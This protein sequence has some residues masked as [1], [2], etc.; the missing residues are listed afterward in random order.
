MHPYKI[1]ST[2][3]YTFVCRHNTYFTPP[4]PSYRTL[5]S[6]TYRLIYLHYST[7]HHCEGNECVSVG[8]C[9]HEK[10]S[11]QHLTARP[12]SQW[13][14]LMTPGNIS[15]FT[16]KEACLMNGWHDL[17]CHATQPYMH[18]QSSA[19]A[20][21]HCMTTCYLKYILAPIALVS[22]TPLHLTMLRY[23]LCTLHMLDPTTIYSD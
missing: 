18:A 8:H 19:S 4:A 20:H 2:F 5:L 11:Y 6:S 15:Y 21:L 16:P 10:A 3:L 22:R 17:W 1:K 7:G 14:L 12:Y 9:L 13:L 23:W